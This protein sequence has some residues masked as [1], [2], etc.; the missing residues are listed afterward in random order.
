MYK[1]QV[2]ERPEPLTH[3]HPEEK[4]DGLHAAS[5]HQ[6]NHFAAEMKKHGIKPEMELYNPGMYR[7]IQ[8]LQREGLVDAP[9]LVQFV[10]GTMTGS[11]PTPWT[12]MNLL[13]ELPPNCLF[14][15]AGV[16][17]TSWQ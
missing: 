13:Q 1:F 16:G 12:V 11:S 14:E 7:V 3:P 15:V 17:P 9:Y 5:Y 6:I 4:L 2:K 10:L 8:D